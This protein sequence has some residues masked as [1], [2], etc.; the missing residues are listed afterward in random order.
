MRLV[1][2][3]IS[4][5]QVIDLQS[6][7]FEDVRKWI[8]QMATYWASSANTTRQLSN[9]NVG[10][11]KQNNART[12]CTPPRDVMHR[13][14]DAFRYADSDIVNA[15][16]RQNG[17]NDGPMED[18]DFMALV[19]LATIVIK[20]QGR[21]TSAVRENIRSS[22]A[23]RDVCSIYA[24][25]GERWIFAFTESPVAYLRGQPNELFYAPR[26]V[27]DVRGWSVV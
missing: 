24:T 23:R 7:I 8:A 18:T 17:G 15:S 6:D 9:S 20:M 12:I 16:E 27:S 2:K 10:T 26:A 25:T 13:G 3:A 11:Q 22:F 5:H 14:D 4:P 21:K 1:S 19:S